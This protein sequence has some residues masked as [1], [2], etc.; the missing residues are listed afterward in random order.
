MSHVGDPATYPDPDPVEPARVV[1]AQAQEWE[2]TY[3]MFTHL[4]LLTFH[5]MLPVIP[6]LVLWLVK[7]ERSPFV[8]DHGREAVN[9]QISLVLYALLVVPIVALMTCGIG[10][11]L[12]IPVYV[13]AVVGMIKAAIAANKGEYFRYPACIRFL[14]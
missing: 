7:R 6:A 4:S 1:D 14:H 12:V 8:D 9:Y 13:L 5:V 2:R 3:A 10:A 11:V